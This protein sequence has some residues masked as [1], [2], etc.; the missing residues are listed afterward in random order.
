METTK[1]CPYCGEEILAV[2][3]KCKHCGRWLNEMHS[4]EKEDRQETPPI[5]TRNTNRI[6]YDTLFFACFGAIV[7]EI[8]S[9]IQTSG[10]DGDGFIS[11]VVSPIVNNVPEWL[12]ILVLGFLWI[13]ILLGLRHFCRANGIVKIPFIALVCLMIGCYLFGL[14]SCFVKDDDIV[15]GLSVLVFVLPLSI[16]TSVLEFITGIKL[17]NSKITHKIGVLFMMASTLPI[18]ALIVEIGLF[19][20][21][22][23]SVITAFIDVFVNVSLLTELSNLFGSVKG[24]DAED[25]HE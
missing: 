25:K 7:L 23:N 1:K 3:K 5:I 22:S 9:A 11:W 6:N 4:G 13:F 17:C 19:G 24:T 12:V 2:A 15:A 14:I 21:A 18:I 10:F 20:E 16:A 8:V